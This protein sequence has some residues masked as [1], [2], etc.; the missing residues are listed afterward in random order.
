MNGR[1]Y[2][3]AGRAL[4]V[5]KRIGKGG[6]GEVFL[7]SGAQSRALKVY[8]DGKALEREAKIN[9][10]VRRQLWSQS[11]LVAY[12]IDV[13]RDSK[14]RFVGFTMGLVENHKPI[15]EL[16]APGARKQNFQRAN[17]PF[18][19]RAAQNIAR[20][21][22]EVHQTGCVIG[23][24]NHS[25][26]LVSQKATAALIDADS[27][28]IA[29]GTTKFFC[30]V[31]VQEYTPPELQGRSLDGLERTTDHDAF[32]LAVIIF[33]ML[34]M[35]RH[36]FSGSST[37][38]DMPLEK[39][40][41]EYR[42]VYSRRR[43]VGM[44]PPPGVCTLDDFIP[45]VADA[46]EQ[47]FSSEGAGGRTPAAD[48]VERLG[49]FEKS[50][51]PCRTNVLH[52][53]SRNAQTCPWCRM[54]QRLGIVLFLPAY[55][56]DPRTVPPFGTLISGFDLSAL[57]ARIEAVKL[58][59]NSAI[60][61]RIA[62]QQLT[63]SVDA[64]A[65]IK[66]QKVSTNTAYVLFAI[67]A[68]VVIAVPV[69]WFVSLGLAGFGFSKL[70]ATS[71]YG[72]KL[73]ANFRSLEE[74]WNRALDQWGARCGVAKGHQLKAELSQLKAE[75]EGLEAEE[76]AKLAKYQTERHARQLESYLETFY[77]ANYKIKGIGPAKLATL[78]SYGIESAAEVTRNRVLNVPGFG[79]VNSKPLFEWRTSVERRFVYD[80][81][82]NAQD[83]LEQQKIRT[84]TAAKVA[85]LRKKLT[86][87]AE[88][89]W[90]ASQQWQR[91]LTIPD[92]ELTL[93]M[94]QIKQIEADGALFGVTFPSL[95]MTPVIAPTAWISKPTVQ[96]TV[97]TGLPLWQTPSPQP[98]HPSCPSC[99]A[100]MVK[101]TAR[102]GH[103]SGRPFWGCSHYPR[104]RGT[105]P[106]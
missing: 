1:D 29:D 84:E 93:V 14:G 50:L 89:F 104:C 73:Q 17:Y 36:P 39:A 77:I 25:G 4:S 9:A 48:W 42:F 6:E 38:G 55:D 92:P 101:R 3:I 60:V 56:V 32:G 27:F 11:P 16:Y 44:V 18:L 28:Q 30:R 85:T 79:A 19:V 49:E 47:T 54:E 91:M 8:T 90:R 63:P 86:E 15:H 78:S 26:V 72:S 80:S 96:R 94:Q 46:F 76:K 61:P 58:P 103:R 40:I 81:R 12:P 24:I 106:I 7:L 53:Y 67:A 62:P 71:D 102:R 51:I 34:S 75:Y 69:L 2:F 5:G 43:N 20:A 68:V 87:G 45:T 22:A 74:R 37:K 57:W 64:Q 13:V 82:P 65:A 66:S 105:R 33:Q 83:A 97:T 70:K 31:G 99:G 59:A 41:A 10:I 98:G 21:V 95:R 35:G 88:E 23:D 52:H 100:K